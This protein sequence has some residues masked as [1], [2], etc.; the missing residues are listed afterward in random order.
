MGP[1]GRGTRT[2]KILEDMIKTALVNNGYGVCEQKTIST[3]LFGNRYIADFV[4]SYSR[5]DENKC[6]MNA[7]DKIIIS[8]KWQQVSGTAEQKLLYEIASL[9]E[10]IKNSEGGYK[11]AY[12]VLGGHGFSN[13]AK[14]YLLSQKHREILKDGEL[15]EVLDLEEITAKINRKEL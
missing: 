10:I 2:G 12:V 7:I 9:I 6:D 13:H 1:G 4:V 11:K 14:K 3:A 5:K 8:C 15:V